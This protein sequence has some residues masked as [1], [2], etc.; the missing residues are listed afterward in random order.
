MNRNVLLCLVAL[1]I[2]LTAWRCGATESW[3]AFRGDGDSIVRGT[4]GP[5]SWEPQGR[6][7]GNWSARLPG[8]GQSSP[9][10]WEETIFVTAV[11]GDEKERFHVLALAM[12]DGQVRWQHDGTSTQRIPDSDT[13]SRGAPTPVVDSQRLYCVFESGD[14]VALTHDGKVVWE[15]SFVKSHGEVRGPHGYASS[16]LLIDGV[17]ILQVA[18]A[19]PSY[20]IALDAASGAVRWKADHPSENGWSSPVA[21]EHQ[22]EKGLVISTS[23]SVRALRATDGATWWYVNGL[24]GNGTATPTVAGDVV[25][26]GVSE[27]RGGGRRRPRGDSTE[28]AAP[29]ANPSPGNGTKGEEEELGCLAIRLGGSGDVTRTHILWK[30][31]KVTCGYASPLVLGDAVYVVK[32]T[33]VVQCLALADGALRWQRRLPGETWASPIGVGQHVLFF[34]KGGGVALLD[35]QSVEGEFV[36]SAVSATD[37]VYGVAAAD[38]SWIVRTGR[39]LLRITAPDQGPETK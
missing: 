8:Y 14:V 1:T 17:L 33:G 5:L 30:A 29:Q 32:K 22:G 9:V 31:P 34:T 13:V 19:G 27:G 25:V 28:A 4:S 37:I 21:I 26:I 12:S 18:H 6:S 7:P 23:G 2:S 10:V 36:E 35:T 38:K 24:R 3:P 39:G 16:P 15:Y 20:A 11:S